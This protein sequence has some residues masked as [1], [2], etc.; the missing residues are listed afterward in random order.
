MATLSKEENKDDSF[1]LSRATTEETTGTCSS[2]RSQ[3]NQTEKNGLKT[4]LG[5]KILV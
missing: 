1:G 3:S 5:T 2:E 4:V